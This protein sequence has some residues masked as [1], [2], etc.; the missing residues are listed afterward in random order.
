MK[1][2]DVFKLIDNSAILTSFA[3]GTIFEI[4]SVVYSS[5]TDISYELTSRSGYLCGIYSETEMNYYLTQLN[6]TSIM[7][8]SGSINTHVLPQG[9]VRY[10]LLNIPDLL[11]MPEITDLY[12]IQNTSKINKLKCECGADKVYGSNCGPQSHSHW[13]ELSK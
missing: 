1:K 6:L 8:S 12:G 9:Q 11:K 4:T 7:G 10:K 3:I 5:L 2:G 13:C